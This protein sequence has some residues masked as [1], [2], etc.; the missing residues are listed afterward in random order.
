M[1]RY[2]KGL[3]DSTGVT[4][5]GVGSTTAT[6]TSL[7]IAP[8]STGLSGSNNYFFTYM[9]APTTSGSTSGTAS[10]LYIAGAPANATTAYALNVA[11]GNCYF[12]G[13]ITIGGTIIGGGGSGVLTPSRYSS[14]VP[15]QVQLDTKSNNYII[16]TSGSFTIILPQL[17]G[18]SNTG[19]RYYITNIGTGTI[20]LSVYGGSSDTF[21]GSTITSLTLYQYDR[22]QVVAY[23]LASGSIWQTY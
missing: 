22:V 12:A 15:V 7:Y 23:Y 9:A 3:Y 6:A 19:L 20:T 11:G 10:T 18:D 14:L 21:D 5:S 13:D 4:I 2:V 16:A 17:T 1:P 8:A